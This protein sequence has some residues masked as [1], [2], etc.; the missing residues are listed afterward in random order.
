MPIKTIKT[1]LEWGDV[2]YLKNDPDQEEYLLVGIITL[3]GN[4]V[5]FI[6]SYYGDE[7]RVFDFECSKEKDKLKEIEGRGQ[8]ES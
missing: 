4:Q 3:P 1:D 5:Q 2:F 7:I 6:L 8:N